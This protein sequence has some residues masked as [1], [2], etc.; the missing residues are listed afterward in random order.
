MN[1]RHT[2]ITAAT[3]GFLGVAFGAFG[4][5]AL[6]PMLIETGR[7]EVYELA[8]RYVF[9]H[10]FALLG[11]GI[12]MHLLPAPPLRYAALFFT[13]GIILFSG[14]LLTL[15]FVR[16]GPI[17]IITPIGG[18]FLLLGWSFF[19]YAMIKRN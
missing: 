11:T 7:L 17:G 18:I 3:F 1:Q 15:S 16:L 2:L 10:T 4:A 14:S 12:T 19:A 9:Y 13:I 5:H 6:K 8:I